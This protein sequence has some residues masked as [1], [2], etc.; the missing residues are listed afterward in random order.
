MH[1]SKLIFANCYFLM[2]ITMDAKW[3]DYSSPLD[4]NNKFC[5]QVDLRRILVVDVSVQVANTKCHNA[6]SS[7]TWCPFFK[8]SS[9]IVWIHGQLQSI[10]LL[11]VAK[12]LYEQKW[13]T[14]HNISVYWQPKRS[15]MQTSLQ[16]TSRANSPQLL[17]IS[18]KQPNVPLHFHHSWELSKITLLSYG[19]LFL[20]VNHT[21]VTWRNNSCTIGTTGWIDNYRP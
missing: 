13:Y 7:Y 17:R 20:E 9:Q 19:M 14:P 12:H 16:F 10:R 11:I 8:V 15:L 21:F 3:F 1:K 6:I 18:V 5:A 4:F 2:T